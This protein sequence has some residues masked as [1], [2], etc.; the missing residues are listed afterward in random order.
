VTDA[1]LTRRF[2]KFS[3][4]YIMWGKDMSHAPKDKSIPSTENFLYVCGSFKSF[5]DKS[6]QFDNSVTPLESVMLFF[7]MSRFVKLN[8]SLSIISLYN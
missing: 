7:I 3:Q 4:A 8:R 6:G 2:G 1:N 5:H